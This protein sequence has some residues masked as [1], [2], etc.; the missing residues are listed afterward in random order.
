MVSGFRSEFLRNDI[1]Y[2]CVT[3]REERNLD[4]DGVAI[5]RG[6]G[7]FPQLLFP[8]RIN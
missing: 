4:A 7:G 5:D 2:G 1:Q 6:F 8:L 3:L